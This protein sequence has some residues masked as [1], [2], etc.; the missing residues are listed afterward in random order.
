MEV[1]DHRLMAWEVVVV[2]EQG[3]HGPYVVAG[4]G[5]RCSKAVMVA[6]EEGEICL[7]KEMRS[8]A[9]VRVMVEAEVGAIDPAKGLL[10][11][12]VVLVTEEEL[13]LVERYVL[14]VMVAPMAGQSVAWAHWGFWEEVEGE[15][16]RK[17]S[18]ESNRGP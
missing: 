15:M 1:E 11:V 8:V 10:S 5:V 7:V 17:K 2:V 4:A 9:A 14:P 12:L 16:E 13:A 18:M 3:G 6:G